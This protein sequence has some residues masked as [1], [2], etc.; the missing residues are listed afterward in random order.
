MSSVF[1]PEQVAASLTV[2]DVKSLFEKE[3]PK[4]LLDKAAFMD[5]IVE[6]LDDSSPV[7]VDD[8]EVN[9]VV[10]FQA[11]QASPGDETEEEDVVME[12]APKVS[13]FWKKLASALAVGDTISL[14]D[15]QTKI[16]QDYTLEAL[17]GNGAQA[18][19]F[20]CSRQDSSKFAV[21][22]FRKTVWME[23]AENNAKDEPEQTR[24]FINFQRECQVLKDLRHECIVQIYN[25]FS[26]DLHFFLLMELGKGDL[27]ALVQKEKLVDEEA[28]HVFS[29]LLQGV[30]YIHFKGIL[31]RDIKLENIIYYSDQRS[32][33]DN[34]RRIDVKIGDFGLSKKVGERSALHSASAVSLEHKMPEPPPPPPPP[35]AAALGPPPGPLE[36]IRATTACGTEQYAAPEVLSKSRQ[37]EGRCYDKE[38]DYF[39]LGMCLFICLTAY[40]PRRRSTQSEDGDDSC[41]PFFE[42]TEASQVWMTMS[43][44]AR[45]LVRGLTHRDYHQRFGFDE[46]KRHFWFEK[47]MENLDSLPNVGLHETLA[48]VTEDAMEEVTDFTLPHLF[49]V[50]TRRW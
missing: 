8:G 35:E 45:D 42:D 27:H 39:S 24:E 46:C 25:I 28:K 18:Q 9:L 13:D 38:V 32:L 50:P 17:L 40:C 26:T 21:K 20:R 48:S 30:Q 19:V 1:G 44:G 7:P 41:S 11:V 5:G 10:M 2:G 43:D 3:R 33:F 36:L 14:E 15:D 16:K 12:D 37:K 4:T 31:H 23:R 6:P 34:H 29:Q 47:T 22:V 49:A